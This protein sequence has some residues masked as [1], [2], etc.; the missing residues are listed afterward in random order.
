M[1][2]KVH[3]TSHSRLS[4]FRWAITPLWL[5]G[6]WRSFFFVSFFCVFLPFPSPADHVLHCIYVPHLCY[7]FICQWTFSLFPSLGSASEYFSLCGPYSWSYKFTT[8]P[9]Q[10]KSSQTIHRG[11]STFAFQFNFI[12]EHLNKGYISYSQ[13][14]DLMF[15]LH[16]RTGAW[17]KIS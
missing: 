9:Q 16:N 12:Y 5:L 7:P 17:I 2:P 15:T 14:T 13:N 1:F 11:M 10:Y 4:G 8:L 6:S 3:L